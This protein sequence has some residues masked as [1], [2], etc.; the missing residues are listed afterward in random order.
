M[1][2]ILAFLTSTRTM[3]VL[4][5]CFALS[6]ASATF[7]END[8][9]SESARSVIYNA[10][11]F[12]AILAIG[13]INIVG[14]IVKKKLYQKEKLS[15]FIFHI[16]FLI[17]IMG[18]AF[19]RYF[20]N[21]GMMHIRDGQ[22]TSQWLTMHT[23]MDIRLKENKYPSVEYNYPVLFS[24]LSGNKFNHKFSFQGHSIQIRLNKYYPKAKKSLI[25]DVNGGPM[26]HLL[27]S[28]DEK[29]EDIILARG[30]SIKFGKTDFAF[31]L[32]DTILQAYTVIFYTKNSES[33]YF[34]S[35]SE[36]TCTS[37]AD[38]S[39]DMLAAN[40]EHPLIPMKLYNFN[41]TP[42]IL[43][44]FI[45]KATATVVPV[46]NKE[47]QLPS[48]LLLD[49]ICDGISKSLFVWGQSE[50]VG[51][52]SNIALNG[53]TM[54][55]RYGAVF[56]SLPFKLKLN[57]FLLKRYPGS[58]SPSSFESDVQL[59]DPEKNINAEKRIFMNHVLRYR[60]FKFYQASYDQDEKGTILSLNHDWLG[61]S[62]TYLGY[63]LLALGMVLSLF[64]KKSRFGSLKKKPVLTNTLT[65]VIISG[66]LAFSPTIKGQQNSIAGQTKLPVIDKRQS[67]KFGKLL[68]QDNGGRIKPLNTLSSE[69]L[70]KIVRKEIYEGQNADQVILGMI[71][72]PE[73]WQREPIIR[74]GHPEIEKILG[75]K[76]N[77]A[78][79][80][81]F[82][83]KNGNNA[84][85]LRSYVADAYR[86]KPD[87]R[88]KL[89]NELI[90]T[91]ERVNI[92]YLIY[93]GMELKI[94]PD[95]ADS[96]H[97]W[98]SPVSA[99]GI[100][101]SD[102]SV[103]VNHIL[104]YY[105]EEV[106]KSMESGNWKTPDDIVTSIGNY[107]KK[108]A[109]YEIPTA[110]RVQTEEFYNRANIFGRLT[111]FYFLIGFLLL[112]IQF[113]H[114]FLPNFNIRYY[115]V[116]ATILIAIAFLFHAFGL[117][118]RWYISG[119]APWS[120]GYEALTFIS[121]ATILA[122]LLF[123][124]KSGIT[125][126]LTAIL[127]ALLLFTAQ[128][129]WMDPQV[130]NLVP[131]LNSY[132]LV[133]HVAVITSSYAFL[134]LGALLAI[135]NLLLMIFVTNGNEERLENKINELSRIIEMTLIA[136]VYL[137]TIGT[138][139]GGV[140]ANESWGRYWGWD[141]KETWALV[142][143]IVYAFILHMRLVPGLKGRLLFNIM[144]LVG[145]SS[146]L[147]TYFG[148]NYYLSGLHS[149]AKG[150]PIPVPAIV[151]YSIAV[152]IILCTLASVNQY[153]R[154]KEI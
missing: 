14:V 78:T 102:D 31:A 42:I 141:P 24:S 94:F 53:V 58:E 69:I 29:E 101:K 148:V 6:I 115:S 57:A 55:I 109:G 63:F 151:Y 1:K 34:K 19:T 147:M 135:I 4:L 79:F 18:A 136:G 154:R 32:A 107:Q 62:V 74:L 77:Y 70:R 98:Y 12:E 66:M 145:Y 125:V 47:L 80:V 124:R 26:I 33:V 93:S 44:E 126:S 48:A 7:I 5:I 73:I 16:A 128:L 37:M 21:E 52:P 88:S 64:N 60:G 84:Y 131:V 152:T 15:L 118:L 121:W 9:G 67:G 153:H 13:V 133:I 71:V 104:Q 116:P 85:T 122:G 90:R 11:W 87:Q 117:S 20:G 41:G 96:M 110:F 134:G 144:S 83:S 17:I 140:W 108:Y 28:G 86:K 51:I 127:A 150:D 112:L 95:P 113:I 130:T 10:H 91:D 129:S 120:N 137:L 100:F 27:T 30:E 92:C 65:L 56:E 40:E 46:D 35:S 146:V 82:F 39:V 23:F 132:W 103:F 49:V 72:Y 139:L 143:V 43:Q 138:F 119:H 50:K 76:T 25:T 75:V 81:D 97:K 105:F 45:A 99:N 68:V 38:Q 61:S 114:I 3:A 89:D 149:Y 111:N 142:S 2:Y 36:A 54:S 59:I 8:F 22:T 123:S 106:N